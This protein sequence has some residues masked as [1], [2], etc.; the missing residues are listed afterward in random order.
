MNFSYTRTCQIELNML[1]VKCCEGIDFLLKSF[2]GINFVGITVHIA[3]ANF[4]D[5]FSR[6]SVPG[7]VDSLT[8][9]SLA[10]SP[11]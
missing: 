6:A 9:S 1:Q 5:C 7:A 8:L 2:I 4:I 10:L 11:T 3:K